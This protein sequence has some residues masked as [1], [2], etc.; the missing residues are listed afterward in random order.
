MKKYVIL[1]AGWIASASLAG[2]AP[3]GVLPGDPLERLKATADL[4]PADGAGKIRYAGMTKYLD[5][6]R[7][8]VTH[9]IDDTTEF[10][11]DC[12]DAMDRY[13]IKA[14]VFVTTAREPISQLWPRL[15]KAITDGH[16]IGS[17][18]R[19]HKCKWP[20]DGAFCTEA[21]SESEVSGSRD[22]ILKNTGQPY[23]WAWCYPCGN[24]AG[25]DFVQ[26][27]LAAAGYLV[28]RNYPD[29]AQ[30]GHIV[31]DLQTYDMNP[32][33]AA[34]TQVV[35]KKGGIAKSGNT[36]LSQLNAKFD[37]VYQRG[38]MYNFLSHPQWLDYGPES[39]Y[40]RHLAY[41]GGRQD[42]WYVPMGPLYAYKTAREATEV[43]ALQP[44]RAQARFAVFNNL[45]PK[46]YN[47][48]ITLAFSL[49]SGL[50]TQV[51]VDG[52]PLPRKQGM[53]DRW[54]TEYFRREGEKLWVTMR[55]NRILEF[56]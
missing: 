55:P 12:I 19:R 53:T 2:Q 13:G 30:D 46:V 32:Y 14:S 36:D 37:E 26:R 1:I 49:A 11:P 15:R 8:T 18:S 21:Y 50:K 25:Q 39:F 22:D 5:N 23:V 56:R 31:P 28:A 38:G 10:V 52:K 41:I 51:F 48:S 34:Y 43:R 27:R 16:E 29:E 54:N 40:E 33:N 45:D 17:H 9:T 20:D 3:I 7:A 47:N 44:G 35:Q 24:C 6:A 4:L 42:V